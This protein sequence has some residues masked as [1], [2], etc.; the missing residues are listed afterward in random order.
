MAISRNEVTTGSYFEYLYQLMD[1]AM[2]NS[3]HPGT[4]PCRFEAWATTHGKPRDIQE[5]RNCMPRTTTTY[6]DPNGDIQWL[7]QHAIPGTPSYPSPGHLPGHQHPY[8]PHTPPAGPLMSTQDHLDLMRKYRVFDRSSTRDFSSEPFRS[9]RGG[10]QHHN[11][12]WSNRSTNKPYSCH[13]PPDDRA[14]SMKA[15]PDDIH[16]M[17]RDQDKHIRDLESALT[18][19]RQAIGGSSDTMPSG[20]PSGRRP[21]HP[22]NF[23]EFTDMISRIYRHVCQGQSPDVTDTRSSASDKHGYGIHGHHL[24]RGHHANKQP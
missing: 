1:A 8:T 10:M 15:R 24:Y 16:Q 4:A 22:T 14:E 3:P 7:G 21:M 17:V 13:G 18:E 23:N 9:Y 5:A 6:T 12:S 19:A 11:K 2:H 20:L